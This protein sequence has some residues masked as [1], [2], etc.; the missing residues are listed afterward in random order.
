MEAEHSLGAGPGFTKRGST[1]DSCATWRLA[2]DRRD[3][4]IKDINTVSARCPSAAEIRAID[5]DLRLEFDSDPTKGV[6][7]PEQCAESAGSRDLTVMQA[8][9]YRSLATLR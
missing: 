5:R 8:R 2:G 3:V 9:V 7:S 4:V 6:M 1:L